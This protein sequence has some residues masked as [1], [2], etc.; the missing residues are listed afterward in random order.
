MKLRVVV[1]VESGWNVLFGYGWSVRLAL[2]SDPT[3]GLELAIWTVG[4][5]APGRV[6]LYRNV[7]VEDPG[8][9]TV[10]DRETWAEDH[11]LSDDGLGKMAG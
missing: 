7:G 8:N 1:P 2:S 4:E 10:A 3:A 9:R 5:M 6:T 11:R